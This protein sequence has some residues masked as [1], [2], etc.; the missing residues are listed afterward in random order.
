MSIAMGASTIASDYGSVVI[1]QYNSAGATITS[2][3]TSYAVDNTAFVIGNG[4]DEANVSDAFVVD[5]SGNTTAAGTVTATGGF[6]GDGSQLTNLPSSGGGLQSVTENSKTGYRR[7]DA[8]AANYGDIGLGA[9]D[10]SNSPSASTTMGATGEN[11]IAMGRAT[12]ASGL[13]ST[14]MGNSTVASG[15]DGATAMGNGTVASGI[16]STAMGSNTEASGN[17][18]TAMGG[19]TRALGN[20]STAMGASTTASGDMSIAMGASTIASDYGSVVIGQYNS[21]GATVTS[22]ATSYAVD[23]TAFVIGNGTDDDKNKSDAFKVLFNGNTTIAGTLTVGAITIPNT[24][25]NAN[26]VLTTDGTGVLGWSAPASSSIADSSV[27][28]A[29]IAD[30]TIDEKDLDAS[31][32]T[33]LGLAD[34]ALQSFTEVDGSVTN[35]IQSIDVASLSGTNLLLSL[36]MD[37]ESNKSIDLSSLQDGTG[38]DDQTASEVLITDSGSLITAT[39]VE[40]ALAENRKAIDVKA[41]IDNPIFTGQTVTV[42][43][44]IKAKRYVLTATAIAATASTTIDLNTGNVITINLSADTTL[45]TSNAAVGTYLIKLVQGVVGN[46]YVYFPVAWKWSGGSAPTVTLTAGKTDIV[47]LIYDGGTFYAAISQNF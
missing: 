14:A 3:A 5:F 42:N 18:S 30:G 40:D 45:T 36:S 46:Y 11:S 44:D 24:A 6:I 8:N 17:G 29:K 22:S 31:V 28:T 38:T 37:N 12:T 1:G 13:N 35:E 25:G 4:T 16:S 34:S 2:N 21:A 32:N 23:N 39:T 7:A 43:N 9:V 15:H 26:D 19:K 27:T 47:T 10:L 20:G 33:S 41:P